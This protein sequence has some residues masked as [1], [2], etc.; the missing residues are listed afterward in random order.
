MSE[1][2]T[3]SGNGVIGADIEQL[4]ATIAALRQGSSSIE[5]ALR[6]A[7]QG[8]EALQGSRWSGQHR[9]QAEAIWARIQG[10]FVPAIDALNQLAARAERFA[11][12][13]EKAA[14]RFNDGAGVPS[15]PSVKAPSDGGPSVTPMPSA[16]PASPV[17]PGNGIPPYTPL[18]NGSTREDVLR[19]TAGCTNYVLRKVNMNDMGR[20]PNAHEWNDVATRAGYALGTVPL[21]GSVMVFE[22]GVLGAHA[23]LGHV[24]YVENVEADGSG[25]M[26]VKISEANVAFHNGQ[27]VWG[28]HTPPTERTINLRRNGDGVVTDERGTPVAVSFIYG[29]KA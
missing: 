27:V 22:P 14:Q 26:R 17:A 8:M 15:G 3:T 16:P 11:D 24:A 12:A 18:P 5:N 28:T 21:K 20:W 2:V 19:N 13:L 23:Q 7:T 29:K 6:Q 10:Q 1:A 25:L 9:Q 4:R